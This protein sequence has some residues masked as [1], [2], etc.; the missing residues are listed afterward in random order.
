MVKITLDI[1]EIKKKILKY[2][3]CIA[4]KQNK[5]L[6]GEYGKRNCKMVEQSV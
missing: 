3:L 1:N 6:G 5:N 4:H 2:K